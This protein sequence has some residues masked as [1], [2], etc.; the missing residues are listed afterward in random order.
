MGAGTGGYRLEEHPV[1]TT[2]GETG[3]DNKEAPSGKAAVYY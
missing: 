2:L 1:V 3:T